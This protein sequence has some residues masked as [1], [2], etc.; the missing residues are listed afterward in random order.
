M[1]EL[2]VTTFGGVAIQLDTQTLTPALPV[3]AAAALIYVLR[4][5]R[6]Q[7]REHLAALMWPESSQERASGNLRMALAALREHVAASVEITRTEVRVFGM[8]DA[9]AFDAELDALKAELSGARKLSAEAL[10]RLDAALRLY[11]GDFMAQFA[12]NDSPPFEA[13]LL[14]EREALRRRYVGA[15]GVLID[16]YRAQK[17]YGEGIDR[18]LRL[19]TA[20]PLHE[21]THRRLMLLYVTSGDRT[22]ALAQFEACQTL[23]WDELGVEPEDETIALYE[24]IASG[25]V[26]PARAPVSVTQTISIIPPTNLPAQ[27]TPFIGREAEVRAVTERVAASRLVTLLGMGGLGKTRLALRSSEMLLTKGLFPNGVFFIDLSPLRDPSH[28]VNAVAEALNVEFQP[29]EVAL[30]TFLKDKRLLLVLDNFEHLLDGVDVVERW[31]RTAPGV[32]VLATSREPL[33]L[34]GENLFDV[35][36]MPPDE[37]AALFTA[38]LEAVNGGSAESAEQITALCERLECWPLALELA[39]GLARTHSVGEIYRAMDKRLNVLQTAMRGVPFRHRTLFNTIDYSFHLLPPEEQAM[40][41]RL[42]VFSGGWTAQAA[43]AVTG[44]HASLL[45][46]LADKGLIRR[47]RCESGERR[48]SMLET[49]R[50]FGKTL[51]ETLGETESVSDAHLAYFAEYAER[52]G[53]ELMQPGNIELHHAVVAEMDNFRAALLRASSDARYALAESRIVAGIGFLMFRRSQHSELLRISEHALRQREK[54]PPRLL[55][56]V[57]AMVGHASHMH[58]HLQRADEAHR[59]ALAIYRQIGDRYGEADM[60]RCLATRDTDL[61]GDMRLEREALAIAQEL[62]D[63]W[64]I[65]AITGNMAATLHNLGRLQEGLDILKVGYEAAKGG[66]EHLVVHL[67]INLGSLS[68]ANGQVEEAINAYREILPVAREFGHMFVPIVCIEL[69]DIYAHIGRYQEALV[70][71]QEANTGRHLLPPSEKRRLD[72]T[73]ALIAYG[74]KDWEGVR[75]LCTSAM[76]DLIFGDI[77]RAQLSELVVGVARID[78][79]LMQAGRWADALALFLVIVESCKE[80]SVTIQ[81][82]VEITQM[83][84]AELEAKLTDEERARAAERAYQVDPKLVFQYALQ[85]LPELLATSGSAS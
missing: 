52:S 63:R 67:F 4:Q 9:N 2:T 46:L 35:P 78:R 62:D 51:M 50:E 69:A 48:F 26:E 33:R 55:A 21:E 60:L 79:W 43:Q 49:L 68:Y 71:Y 13:W 23:L 29:L 83:T 58:D 57:L 30:E 5:G 82:I 38:R 11:S 3:K 20:D 19:L 40:F 84:Q 27:M 65:A 44:Q 31:L 1:T 75:A 7:T 73:G 74:L 15:A 6:A 41:R 24:D 72:L 10:L 36:V 42:A 47:G 32:R 8:L 37:A 39:A 77:A 12:L 64:L 61:T 14:N 85:L 45:D 28:V 53:V 56:D 76:R 25:K 17:R 16:A 70:L 66:L 80:M 22:S 81:R 34:Y 54:L 59:E 18:G